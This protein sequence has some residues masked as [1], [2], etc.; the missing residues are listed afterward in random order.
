MKIIII[1]QPDLYIERRRLWL[2][3]SPGCRRCVLRGL[4]CK[5]QLEEGTWTPA[6]NR[7][8]ALASS[9]EGW[10]GEGREDPGPMR[11]GLD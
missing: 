2:W 6:E 4:A 7:K 10:E 1:I 9:E 8:G 11:K 5:S 3:T